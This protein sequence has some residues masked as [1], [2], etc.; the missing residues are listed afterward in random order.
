M[1]KAVDKPTILF[2][3][4]F[5]RDDNSQVKGGQLYACRALVESPLSNYVNW[6]KLDT[7]MESVPPPPVWRRIRPAAAR[8]SKFVAHLLFSRVDGVLIFASSG[9]SFYEKGFMTV[10]AR[11]AGKRV[12]LC[13][14]SGFII[15]DYRQSW[16]MRRV[17]PIVVRF[18]SAVICQGRLWREFFISVTGLPPDRFEIIGNSIDV[19]PYE[20]LAVQRPQSPINIL[21]M[22]WIEPNKGVFD[23][24]SVVMRYRL[25]L[26]KVRFVICG[27]GCAS[28]DL[29]R[30]IV[31]YEVTEL[32]D[33]RGWIDSKEKLQVL[34][35]SDIYVMLSYREG[36]PNALLEAMASGRA[37]LATAIGAVPE[38]VE[39][40]VTGFLCQPGDIEEIGQ[41]LVE[42]CGDFSLRKR[43]GSAGQARVKARHTAEALWPIWY[44]VLRG[45]NSPPAPNGERA[46]SCAE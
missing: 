5:P 18:S 16:L 40:G 14:R 45:E 28:D 22:G 29:K 19:R 6:I 23:L 34:A 24:L 25:E 26:A 31:E 17:I 15:D 43:L 21:F 20:S 27:Q 4:A 8:I 41:R 10:I 12:V 42:L 32:F 46:E 1:T 35:T 33:L 37:V 2:V 13:P 30:A 39:D 3:G 44:R 36:L 7:T 11:A 9:F 38:L